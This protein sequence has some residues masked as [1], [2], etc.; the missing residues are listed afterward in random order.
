MCIVISSYQRILQ[1]NLIDRTRLYI[2]KP[3]ECLD[4]MNRMP[5]LDQQSTKLSGRHSLVDYAVLGRIMPNLQRK[6]TSTRI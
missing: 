2:K 1:M 5:K 6:E 4:L 3:H